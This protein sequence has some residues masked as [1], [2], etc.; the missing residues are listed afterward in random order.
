MKKRAKN[1]SPKISIRGHYVAEGVQSFYAQHG[2]DY[3]NPHEAIIRQ[4][5]KTLVTEHDLDLSHILDLA[6]GSGEITLALTEL[7]AKKVDG[8]D[9]YTG[10]AYFARTGQVADAYTFEQIAA[11]VLEKRRYS[12]VVCSFALHLAE[13]SRL[14]LLLFHLAQ[15]SDTLLI[16]TPHKRPTIRPEW[17]WE[18]IQELMLERVRGRLYHRI[19]QPE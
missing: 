10:E 11:G 9:P 5:V 4:I 8:I 19:A 18:L 12:M 14:P 13:A 3:R 16:L 15:I 17:G 1:S 6:C 2:A 7:G